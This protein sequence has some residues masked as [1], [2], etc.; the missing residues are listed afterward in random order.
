VV[1]LERATKSAREG[2]AVIVDGDRGVVILDPDEPTLERYT[3]RREMAISRLASLRKDATLP[4]VTKDGTRI[5]LFG[6]IEFPYEVD[7]LLAN[8]GEG[9][10]LYRTE[11]LYLTCPSEPTEE[12]HY[13][14]YCDA[15]HRLG[16]LPMTIRTLDLGADKYTQSHTL[17]PERNPFLGCRS[18]R[19][20]LQHLPV[21]KRQLRAILRAAVHGNVQI[22]FPL[23]CNTSELHQAN[24]ILADVVE[25]LDADHIPFKR[26]VPTGMMVETPS[27]ALMANIF[28]QE[29]AFFSIGT[30]DLIQYTLVVDRG[31]E[32]VANLYTGAHPAVIQ[33]MRNVVRAGRRFHIPVSMCGELAAEP[34][35]TMLLIGLGLRM[36]S[37]TPSSIPGIK[38]VIRAVE[39]SECERLARK[40]GSFDSPHR[41]HSHLKRAAREAAPEVFE[42]DAD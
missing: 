32:R 28:A 23:I 26:N 31:N 17:A 22:M 24:M 5:H 27:A 12:D 1:G 2:A 10:G 21:F 30:N 19:Y 13:E 33:L 25:E 9:V 7:D 35:Y 8:E 36:F 29:A 41:I 39:V 6:N 4:A 16:D 18:I 42:S 37:V 38:R 34:E 20:C 15:I 14:A 40:V 11:Y 3:R